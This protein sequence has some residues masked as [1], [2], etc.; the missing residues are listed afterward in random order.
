MDTVH[1]YATLGLPQ[2]ASANAVRHAYRAALQRYH[3]DTGAGNV[4]ALD[5]V[6]AAFRQLR[7]ERVAPATA[8]RWPE[9]PAPV[10]SLLDVYA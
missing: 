4:R 7:S 6:T 8:P 3:P 10:G 1:A 5:A 2:T 9:Q